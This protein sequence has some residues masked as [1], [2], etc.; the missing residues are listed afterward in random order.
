MDNKRLKPLKVET[1]ANGSKRFIDALK[2]TTANTKFISLSCQVQTAALTTLRGDIIPLALAANTLKF[3]TP[4]IFH[5]K[6]SSKKS[7]HVHKAIARYM[8]ERFK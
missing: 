6:D 5:S 7:I 4:S 1:I 8:L 3:A 2:V